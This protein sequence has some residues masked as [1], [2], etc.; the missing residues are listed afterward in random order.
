MHNGAVGASQIGAQ[1]QMDVREVRYDKSQKNIKGTACQGEDNDAGHQYHRLLAGV[2]GHSGAIAKAR[3]R[4]NADTHAHLHSLLYLDLVGIAEPVKFNATI[5]I[6]VFTPSLGLL[7]PFF[8]SSLSGNA[9]SGFIGV[10]ADDYSV[11]HPQVDHLA[12]EAFVPLAKFPAAAGSAQPVGAISSIRAIATRGSTL[13]L[14]PTRVT[15]ESPLGLAEN[16]GDTDMK[17]CLPTELRAMVLMDCT[18]SF[19]DCMA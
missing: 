18:S 8:I 17:A 6:F 13:G 16:G 9:N 3:I 19:A 4:L 7:Q 5:L 15:V 1:L 11:F 12:T 2:P 10:G 14:V